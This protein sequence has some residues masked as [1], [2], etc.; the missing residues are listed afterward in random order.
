MSRQPTMLLTLKKLKALISDVKDSKS[1]T[2]ISV[3]LWVIGIM[4]IGI[5]ALLSHILLGG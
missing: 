4:V 3:L 2:E 1:K 5:G